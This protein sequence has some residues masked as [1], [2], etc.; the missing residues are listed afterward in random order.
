TIQIWTCSYNDLWTTDN[1]TVYVKGINCDANVP[2]KVLLKPG[3]DYK[4]ALSVGVAAP[5]EALQKSVTFRLGFKQWADL[6][7]ADKAAESP[8]L[9]WSNPVTLKVKE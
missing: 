3:E 1:S 7:E 5:A 8:S 9:I 6:W 2:W 4:R